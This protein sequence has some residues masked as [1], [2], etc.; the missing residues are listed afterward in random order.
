MNKVVEEI[1]KLEI[2]G[3]V[4]PA[5][6][7]KYI[8]RDGANKARAKNEQAKTEPDFVAITIL[9]EIIYW[10]RPDKKGNERF[11]DDMLQMGAKQIA[12]KFS[13][14]VTQ[15][16]DALKRLEKQG[17][18]R[19][20]TRNLV[21]FGKA[22]NNVPFVEP[23]P[24]KIKLITCDIDE[25]PVEI[26]PS[27]YTPCDDAMNSY[28][29]AIES[30]DTVT[31]SYDDDTNSCDAVTDTVRVDSGNRTDHT[32]TKTIQDYTKN[33]AKTTANITAK[34]TAK[35]TEIYELSYADDEE[36]IIDQNSHIFLNIWKF[37]C[38]A[39]YKSKDQMILTGSEYKYI[40]TLINKAE[41]QGTTKESIHEP[42]REYLANHGQQG[43][44][45]DFFER[46]T[47]LDRAM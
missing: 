28:D 13:M 40:L 15:V 22:L 25:K 44:I 26:P 19:T 8:R 42:M 16:K 29:N 21:R 20:E 14:C 10:Y 7:Y 36:V 39:K 46:L 35:T 32:Y 31:C 4:A 18:I 12:P 9:A 27:P 23:I 6:W 41:S 2:K 34:N 24:E 11:N 43:D 47:D 33:T 1:G 17:Y 3:N 30:C 5:S 45:A 37:Y 38:R